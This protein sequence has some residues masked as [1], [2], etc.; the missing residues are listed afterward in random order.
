MRG[1]FGAHNLM[2]NFCDILDYCGF[3][4]LGYSGSDYDWYRRRGGDLI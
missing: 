3:M 4:D 1:A 2:Q